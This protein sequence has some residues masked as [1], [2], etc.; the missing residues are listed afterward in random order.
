MATL[1]LSFDVLLAICSAIGGMLSVRTL[2]DVTC[3]A[4]RIDAAAN[5]DTLRIAADVRVRTARL[6]L[7]MF[8]LLFGVGIIGAWRGVAHVVTLHSFVHHIALLSGS[9]IGLIVVIDERRTRA[10]LVRRIKR[11]RQA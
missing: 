10:R 5:G 11:R 4:C 7:T 2:R 9:I 1:L 6:F 8:G 3:D